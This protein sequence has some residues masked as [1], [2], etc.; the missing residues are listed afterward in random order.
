MRLL[1]RRLTTVGTSTNR[2]TRC[3]FI[4]SLAFSMLRMFQMQQKW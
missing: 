2:R 1:S 4:T 3:F